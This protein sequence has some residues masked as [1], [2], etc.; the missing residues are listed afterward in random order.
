VNYGSCSNFRVNGLQTYVAD[1]DTRAPEGATNW[2]VPALGLDV[3]AGPN[4]SALVALVLHT[5]RRATP[6][7]I[8]V[9]TPL[10]LSLILQHTRVAAGM[11]IKGTVIFTNR[12]GSPITVETCAADAWLEVGLTNRHIPYYPASPLIACPPMVQLVPGVTRVPITVVTTYQ[13]CTQ[14]SSSS[15]TPEVPSCA[16]G[17]PPLPAGTYHTKV[18]TTGLPPDMATPN[19]VRVTLTHDLTLGR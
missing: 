17:P 5:I 19:V 18:I 8:T 3:S 7:D 9:S 4:S 6:R 15:T 11:P 13:A 10:S 16:G 14:S 12:T 2:A 1:C